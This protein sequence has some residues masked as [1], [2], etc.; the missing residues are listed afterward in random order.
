MTTEQQSF[1]ESNLRDVT[2]LLTIY[3]QYTDDLC[4]KLGDVLTKSLPGHKA[5]VD[6]K[7]EWGC[8]SDIYFGDLCVHFLLQV[9]ARGSQTDNFEI[10][11]WIKGLTDAQIKELTPDYWLGEYCDHGHWLDWD[12]PKGFDK[13]A[14]AI[15]ALG[16]RANALFRLWKLDRNT[17]NG[18]PT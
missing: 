3:K 17:A 14:D 4:D 1:L 11:V 8:T 10:Y 13:S 2:S 16:S 7:A 9:P 18:E 5:I 6:H 15:D 12:G